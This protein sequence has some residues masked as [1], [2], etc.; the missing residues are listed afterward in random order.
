MAY[1]D[2][3][4]RPPVDDGVRIIGNDE[5]AERLEQD[6]VAHRVVVSRRSQPRVR[7]K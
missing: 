4:K 3:D 2:D 7:R 6:D 1:D 5:A